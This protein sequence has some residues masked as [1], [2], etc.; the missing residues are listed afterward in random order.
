MRIKWFSII[1]VLGMLFVLL[2]HFYI[3]FFPGGF[4]GVD[5]FF[6]L[7]GY[8]TTALFLDEYAKHQAIDF[9]GFFKRRFYRIFPPVV[10]TLLVTTPLALLVRNDFIAGI[11]RQLMA[12]LG[13]MTN[14][15]EIL[16]GASYEN[17]FTPYLF[18]HTWSL[19][20]EVHFYLLWALIIWGMTR[21][22]KT[23]GQLRGMIFLTS[24]GLFVISFL[25]M[26]ISSFFVSSFSTIYFATWTHIFPFFLGSILASLTGLKTLT[27]PFE[28]AMTKWNLKQTLSL[29]LG[30]LAV[31][32]LL[33]LFL[34][35]D[36]IWT[37]LFGFLLSSLATAIM[38]YATRI[39]HEKTETVKEPAIL[40][41]FSNIS[42]G[43]YLFHWPFYT[44]FSQLLS[45][46]LAVL[47]TLVFSIL[48]ATL[49]F[50]LIEPYLA[51]KKGAFWNVEFD[52]KPY[53]KQI[54]TAATIFLIATIGISILAPRLGNFERE[55]L[56]NNL[57]QS[58]NRM[59]QTLQLAQKGKASSFEVTEGLTIIGDSVTLRSVEQLNAFFPDAFID[60]QGSRNVSQATEILQN[61]IDNHALMKE[62][63]IATGVNITYSYEEDLEKIISILPNGHHL[64]LVTPY[65]GNFAQY[66]DPV[67]EKYA[68]YARQLAKKYDFIAIADWN[69]VAKNNPQIWTGSDNIH[70]GS[71]HDTIVEGATLFAQ[72]I[73]TALEQ[74][75]KQP[76]KNVGLNGE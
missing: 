39:L 38:I 7:S 12:A 25:T 51:G 75:E 8:L 27:R 71:N 65:D 37:Y 14:F 64:I 19:A 68:N 33:L 42:Y 45:H 29:I 32:L 28:K 13:F 10:L 56:I 47:V 76:V 17:Q 4:V 5:L 67:A 58:N 74:V 20:I 61:N 2:Y 1:R 23:L 53:N 34:P 44:I 30:G 52:L 43:I 60:A 26:F 41:F 35:F 54:W 72:T 3:S 21:L 73:Q 18:L 48:F 46:T 9:K 16:A 62:V 55:S 22:A 57:Y 31:E 15:F 66:S 11:G 63:V 70:Y 69:T 49:S 50:Y 59:G 40:L 6:T 36:S 24:S